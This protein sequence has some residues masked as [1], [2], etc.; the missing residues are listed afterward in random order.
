MRLPK[1]TPLA[2]VITVF[3]SGGL[4]GP[5]MAEDTLEEKA[6]LWG[7]M[8][9]A[10]IHCRVDSAHD[11]G[12][13]VVRYFQRQVGNGAKL[14]SLKQIYGTKLIEYAHKT[15][16]GRKVGNGCGPFRAKYNKVFESLGG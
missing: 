15:P 16:S 11:F 1:L 6:D 5:A 10:A 7:R 3:I 9:G 2:V 8:H 13:A 12:V 4:T 14:E